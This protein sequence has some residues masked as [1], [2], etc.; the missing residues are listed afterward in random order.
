MGIVDN[1]NGSIIYNN[2]KNK[3]VAG[4]IGQMNFFDVKLTHKDE[5]IIF[6]KNNSC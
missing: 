3:F 6:K 2:P 1:D 4:F 5:N